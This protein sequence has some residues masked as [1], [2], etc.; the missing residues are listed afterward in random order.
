MRHEDKTREDLFAGPD[1]VIAFAQAYY[2]TEFP[3]SARVG[4][5]PAETL[6]A[7]AHSGDLPDAR[8]RS[9][10]FNCSECFRAY[11][12]ARMSKSARAASGR[13]RWR[14]LSAVPTLFKLPRAWA[15]AGAFCLVVVVLITAG[16]LWRVREDATAVVVNYPARVSLPQSAAQPGAVNPQ[17]AAGAAEPP[18]T[19]G[20][21]PVRQ[22]TRPRSPKAAPKDTRPQTA[23]RIVD[24]D[25]KQD[26]LLRGDDEAQGRHRVITL[27]PER[28]RLRLKMPRGSAPGRYTVKVVDAFGK[29][30]LTAAA[31]SDGRRLKVDLDLRGLTARRC[32]LC[33]ARDG[34]APDCYQLSVEGPPH[35]SLK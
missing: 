23:L 26:D 5:P 14:G 8:L 30:L 25:L 20:P 29:P 22:R 32:R 6:R 1:E 31:N 33:L 18:T 27:S 10:L 16:L 34:E 21:A 11:R 12:S 17:G 28:H 4:C 9:H 19:P 35:S 24:I 13:P 15:A 2:A 3:N 7:V